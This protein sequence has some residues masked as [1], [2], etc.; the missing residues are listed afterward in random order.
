[1]GKPSDEV[2]MAYADGQLDEQQSA[3]IRQAVAT[4]EEVRERV[5][6]FRQSTVLLQE[7]YDAPLR[8]PVPQ[9]LVDT[10]LNYNPPSPPPGIGERLATFFRITPGWRPAHA[11]V[12]MGILAIGVGLGYLFP[13][14]I[15]PVRLDLSVAQKGDA[16]HR[17]L[18]TTASGQSFTLDPQGV[19]VLPVATFQDKSNAFCRPYDVFAVGDQGA[20]LAQGI[21]C[22]N[23]SGQWDTKVYIATGPK[24]PE[25][26]DPLPGYV[27]AS[28]DDHGFVMAIA[29]QLMAAP[30]LSLEDESELMAKG[31]NTENHGK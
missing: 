15:S 5:D 11:L 4:D 31:W 9:R 27:P 30:P 17:G 8:E 24:A 16:F 19:R 10:V 22:R 21:A 28:A 26:E 29:D 18:D 12:A 2:L 20:P 25:T 7:A 6:L 14:D 3:A 23:V 1:M 13:R